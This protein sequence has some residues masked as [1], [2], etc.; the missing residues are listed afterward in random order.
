LTVD[1]DTVTGQ[2]MVVIDTSNAAYAKGKDYSVAIAAGTVNSVSVVGYRLFSFSIE[3]RKG[4]SKTTLIR[5]MNRDEA[6]AENL[7][8]IYMIAA[9]LAGKKWAVVGSNINFY[10]SDGTTI[11]FSR[12]I[13][14][15]PGV[16]P[17]TSMG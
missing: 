9:S 1:F 13:A 15:T 8:L 16:D 17:L 12:P 7:S 5:G 14:G 3:N 11:L 2:N 4:I 6:D 10:A